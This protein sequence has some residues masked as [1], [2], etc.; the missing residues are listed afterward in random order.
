MRLDGF[1]RHLPVKVTRLADQAVVPDAVMLTL[2]LAAC[3]GAA[4]KVSMPVARPTAVRSAVR[5][6]SSSLAFV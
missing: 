1:G 3:A 5:W 2:K 6:R 4:D